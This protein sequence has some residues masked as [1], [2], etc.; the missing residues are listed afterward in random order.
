MSDQDAEQASQDGRPANSA[1]HTRLCVDEH[2]V[3][4]VWSPQGDALA[5]AGADGG[6]YLLDAE[7]RLRPRRIGEHAGGAL[8]VGFIRG[9]THVV[10]GGQGDELQIHDCGGDAPQRTLTMPSTWVE[11]ISNSA[12]GKLLAVAAG[13]HVQLYQTDTLSLLHTYAPLPATVAGLAFAPRGRVL[14]A[15]SYGGVQLLTPFASYGVRK[16]AWAGACIALAWRPDASV[17]AV[18]GQDASVQFW[19]LAKGKHSH[20]SG[21]ATKVRELSWDGTGRWLATGGG[22][23]TLWDFKTGPE[24]RLP[25]ML[26]GHTDRIVC[27]RWQWRGRLLA[28]VS[29]DGVLMLWGRGRHDM[30]LKAFRL[31]FVPT[32]LAWS[33][34]D[35]LLALGGDGGQLAVIDTRS[36]EA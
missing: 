12:D 33:P 3:A 27:L 6:V 34:D 23:L 17:I 31:A 2:V 35:R 24:G 7:T 21:Y 29:R 36:V 13:R 18:G 22:G 19:R 32:A 20:M 4:L 8:S 30:P 1:P 11:H 15:A 9:G 25:Q 5:V 14:A 10:S 16:L 26:H 28:S